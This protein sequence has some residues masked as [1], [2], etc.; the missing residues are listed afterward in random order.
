M[1]EESPVQEVVMDVF[2][3]NASAKNHILAT[4]ANSVI[5]S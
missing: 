3:T 4:S 5:A 2:A 1:E